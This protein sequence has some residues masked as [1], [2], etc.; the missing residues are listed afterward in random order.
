VHLPTKGMP[1][2]RV[3]FLNLQFGIYEKRCYFALDK[4][5][6]PK[7][8]VTQVFR[9]LQFHKCVELLNILLTHCSLQGSN[10][11]CNCVI[12]HTAL[13]N[14]P[15]S[16]RGQ[17]IFTINVSHLV[18]INWFCEIFLNLHNTKFCSTM[19]LFAKAKKIAIFVCHF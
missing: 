11:P 16:T 18:F 10:Y 1:K 12:L 15:K 14:Q 5:S 17:H 2:N 4:I 13:Q 7:I 19:I 9:I 8:N 3:I 6:I